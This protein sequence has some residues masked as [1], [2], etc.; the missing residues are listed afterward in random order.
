MDGDEV[1]TWFDGI[2]WDAANDYAA[3]VTLA[4]TCDQT[5]PSTVVCEGVFEEHAF[6]SETSDMQVMITFTVEDGLI[7][8][9]QFDARPL[10]LAFYLSEKGRD[11]DQGLSGE[12]RRWVREN[13]PETGN[14]FWAGHL[15]PDNVEKHRE[16]VAEWRAQS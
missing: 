13:H 16:L 1:I 12:Y 15:T 6:I 7:T 11:V 5:D 3:G 14:L 10:H 4:Y 9:H 2:L 8:H